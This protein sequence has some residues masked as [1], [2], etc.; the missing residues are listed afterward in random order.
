MFRCFRMSSE[1][2][3]VTAIRGLETDLYN[4]MLAKAK[5]TSKNVSELMNEAMKAYLNQVQRTSVIVG[6]GN[7]IITN[8]DLAELGEVTF[9]EIMNLR[10]SEDID[11]EAFQNNVLSIDNCLNVK[12]PKHI[13]ADAM[14][15]A[16]GCHNISTYS[17]EEH[18]TQPQDIIRIGGI[19]S[20]EI[21]KSDLESVSKKILFEDIKELKL[22]PDIDADAVNRYIE[23]IRR[24]DDLTVPK[25]IFLLILTK[26][27]E[28]E[29]VKKY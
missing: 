15:K 19:S 16:K 18:K 14:K 1:Q 29:E 7:V 17:V 27:R 28:C 25:N 21:S 6:E 3:D 4:K 8:K 24:V 5:E 9:K 20:L 11:K 26:T 2:K 23:V 13:Y 12:V 10:F 22:S